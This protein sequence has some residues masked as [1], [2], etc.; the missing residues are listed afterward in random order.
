MALLSAWLLSCVF[1]FSQDCIIVVDATTSMKQKIARRPGIARDNR[2]EK[3]EL[4]KKELVGYLT[5]KPLAGQRVCIYFFNDG[6]KTEK[7][8]DFIFRRQAD[9]DKAIAFANGYDEHI[10]GKNTHLWS[11]FHKALD[12]GEKNGFVLPPKNGQPGKI[13]TVILLSDGLDNQKVNGW[14]LKNASTQQKAPTQPKKPAVLDNHKWLAGQKAAHWLLVGV[15]KDSEV[16]G[17]ITIWEE[18]GI[19]NIVTK[20]DQPVF[21][22]NI[23]LRRADGELIKANDKIPEGERVTMFARGEHDKFTWEILDQSERNILTK[24]LPGAI[25]EYQFNKVGTF[26]IKVTG[27]YKGG[28]QNARATITVS[29][30]VKPPLAE[31]IDIVA[32][33]GMKTLPPP[34]TDGKYGGLVPNN[35]EVWTAKERVGISVAFNNTSTIDKLDLDSANKKYVVKYNWRFDYGSLT[36][37]YTTRDPDV[38]QIIPRVHGTNGVV[39]LVVT[40]TVSCV[41]RG[42]PENNG[43]NTSRGSLTVHQFKIPTIRPVGEGQA[44]A[45]IIVDTG[46]AVCFLIL[47]DPIFQASDRANGSP[48]PE[49]TEFSIKSGDGQE[50][51]GSSTVKDFAFKYRKPNAIKDNKPDP[52]QVA[53]VGNLPGGEPFEISGPRVSVKKLKSGLFVDNKNPWVGEK[54]RLR[55][56]MVIPPV[57]K[58]DTKFIWNLGDGSGPKKGEEIDHFYLRGD[59][60][61]V[62]LTIIRPDLEDP[63]VAK[64]MVNV[65]GVEPRIEVP[66]DNLNVFIGQP[67][68]FKVVNVASGAGGAFPPKTKIEWDFGDK[69]EGHREEVSKSYD[70]GGAKRVKVFVQVPGQVPGGYHPFVGD[71]TINVKPVTVEVKAGIK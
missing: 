32:G 45:D 60:Q 53:A 63:I 15:E 46:Q 69:T 19:G 48:F 43:S 22:P 40:L 16:A 5:D 55:S 28:D 50:Q 34:N 26:T 18:E 8:G 68:M 2:K 6:D 38:P 66:P 1:L 67:I 25:Q 23:E 57:V 31:S 13:P 54:I 30:P 59:Q 47:P 7:V 39:K 17:L 65:R 37:T 62:E 24:P 35:G 10:G 42:K 52:Y 12:F 4:V 11:S 20:L 21:P 49:G 33:F 3:H 70:K 58:K 61:M 51:E 36:Y 41:E 56:L 14:V 71:K 29:P 27:T 44:G 64:G 9:K